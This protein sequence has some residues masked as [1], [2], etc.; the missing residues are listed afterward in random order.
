MDNNA[1]IS[2]HSYQSQ[3]Y[4]FEA[5]KQ[6]INDIT[7]ELRKVKSVV[8]NKDIILALIQCI[9]QE[10][11]ASRNDIYR[12]ALEQVVRQTPDDL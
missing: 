9:E 10:K 4:A 11:D 8:T 1:A 7:G 5:E 2:S 3:L 6:L 12:H